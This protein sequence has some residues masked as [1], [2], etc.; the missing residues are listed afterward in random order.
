MV[1][2]VPGNHGRLTIGLNHDRAVAGSMT[3]RRN[4]PDPF[5]NRRRRVDRLGQT[6]IKNRLHGVLKHAA[7]DIEE[8][9]RIGW[10]AGD[11]VV[12]NIAKQLQLFLIHQI[13]RVRKG[14]DPFTVNQLRVP[15]H[16]VKMQVGA[17]DIVDAVRVVTGRLHVVQEGGR[18][19]AHDVQ[20]SA[21]ATVADAGVHHHGRTGR[22]HDQRMNAQGE[23]PFGRDEVGK[24]PLDLFHDLGCC[25]RQHIRKFRIHDLLN[26]GDFGITYLPMHNILL[27]CI[28][29][30]FLLPGVGP[31]SAPTR[32][33][34]LLCNWS[35]TVPVGRGPCRPSLWPRSQPA[36]TNP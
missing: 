30:T 34:G 15:A 3:R 19:I 29:V 10:Q 16:M 21:V 14:R 6:G 1:N 33:A 31:F 4:Q 11:H 22:V 23:R 28:V 7:L 5:T 27:F 13:G 20:G 17:H 18:K 35:I 9:H 12:V 36:E 2:E 26:L 24:E 8:I 32:G 25:G